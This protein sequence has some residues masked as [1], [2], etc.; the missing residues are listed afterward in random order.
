MDINYWVAAA[1]LI[2]VVVLIVYLIRRNRK[3][4]AKMERDMARSEL[5]PD[6]HNEN[7]A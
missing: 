2:I 4:Q 3:D 1:V 7:E 5:K 6:K